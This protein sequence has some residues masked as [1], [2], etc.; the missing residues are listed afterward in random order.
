MIEHDDLPL[1]LEQEVNLEIHTPSVVYSIKVQ[2][3]NT[4]QP[5]TNKLYESDILETFLQWTMDHAKSHS[6][7]F[8][9]D[10]EKYILTMPND[11]EKMKSF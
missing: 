9:A 3:I 6:I 2:S 7:E 11:F 4:N 8:I 5:Q 10:D 1:N